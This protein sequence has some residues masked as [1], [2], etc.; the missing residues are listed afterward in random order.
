MP[1]KT[2]FYRMPLITTDIIAPGNAGTIATGGRA[3][4]RCIVS[5]RAHTG[6]ITLL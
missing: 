2:A 6:K 4:Q 1:G 3:M 5:H